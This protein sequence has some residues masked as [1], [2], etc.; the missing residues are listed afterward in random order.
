MN[1]K[2]F[3]GNSSLYGLF[4]T[5]RLAKTK[6]RNIFENIMSTD[7][8]SPRAQIYLKKSIWLIIK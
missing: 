4:L 5:A 3:I 8:K 1:I 7:I 6:L 2:I